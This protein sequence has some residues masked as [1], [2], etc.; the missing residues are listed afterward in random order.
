MRFDWDRRK[1]RVNLRIHGI[2]FAEATT[3]FRD[4]LSITINDPDHSEYEQ[5]FVDIGMTNRRRL[6]VVSYAEREDWTRIISARLPT[7]DER[8][9]YEETF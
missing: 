8:S 2:S 3:V 9:L 5:R 1:A 7:R 4:P 6:V